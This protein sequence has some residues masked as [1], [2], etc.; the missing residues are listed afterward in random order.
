[1]KSN[2]AADD[3][4]LLVTEALVH[5]FQVVVDH[6]LIVAAVHVSHLAH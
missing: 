5:G 1:V 4:Q 3:V 6:T 2:I